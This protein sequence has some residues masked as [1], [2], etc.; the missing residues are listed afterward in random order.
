MKTKYVL[1]SLLLA[2]CLLGSGCAQLQK[3]FGVGEED[4]ETLA[5]LPQLVTTT[6]TTP[7]ATEPATETTTTAPEDTDDEDYEETDE[8]TLATTVTQVWAPASDGFASSQSDLDFDGKEETVEAKY[9]ADQG[10]AQLTV[11]EASQQVDGTGISN[12][13]VVDMDGIDGQLEVLLTVNTDAGE[14]TYAY[15]YKN[16]EL[17]VAEAIEGVPVECMDGVLTVRKTVN[18]LGTYSGTTKYI[19]DSDGFA[20]KRPAGSYWT[21]ENPAPL[22]LKKKMTVALTDESVEV[23]FVKTDLAVGTVLSLTKTDADSYVTFSTSEGKECY[24]AI[25]VG[26][27]GKVLFGKD[28][29]TKYFADLPYAQ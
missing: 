22:T 9:L 3:L 13:A 28:A 23:G 6:T 5:T 16:G 10:K 12:F 19:L 7:A 2:V 25:T 17:T 4:E 11:G 29:E 27:D 20:L 18:I 15:R 21:I 24:V 26:E 1:I 14:L 8:T